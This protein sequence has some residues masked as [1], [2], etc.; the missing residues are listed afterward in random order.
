MAPFYSPK[1]AL[2]KAFPK[3]RDLSKQVNQTMENAE[4]EL[5]KR[6][7]RGCDTSFP[8]A[9]HAEAEWR[10]NCT[11]DY[12]GA[13]YAVE[14][15]KNSLE[16]SDP[17]DALEQDDEGSFAPGTGVW[18]I[19]LDRSTDQLLAR[20]WPWPRPSTFLERINGPIRMVTYLQDLCWSDV[21]R[22]G[23][24]NR[25]ELNLAVSVIVRLIYNG[26][27]AGYLSGPGF[28]PVLE[29]FI[30]DW[31]D[32][33]S[34]F[35]GM[36]YMV[37]NGRTI[38]MPDL[39]LTFHMVRYA[40]HLVRWWPSLIDTL[41]AIRESTYPQGWLDKSGMTDHNNY[42]V[43]ELFQRGW[44]KMLP[45]QRCQAAFHIKEMLNWCLENS[46]DDDGILA[47]P[48]KGDPIPESYYFAAAF[49]D[50][51]GF[52]DS[53]KKFWT[54]DNLQS[55]DSR[56]RGMIAKLKRFNQDFT[57]IDNTLERLGVNHRPWSNAIL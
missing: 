53:S 2:F 56:K 22:C 13:V 50:T 41:L 20:Q 32:P 54:N 5:S 52:F 38:T 15:L 1:A 30:R 28:V 3:M 7:L 18:F 12:E 47:N 34:G 14:Q 48:D 40:P 21:E 27:Q 17:L 42:D 57:V 24:D 31:Q 29:R 33:D 8:R 51:I 9:R 49:L 46:V 35:F 25:K 39:S 55:P 6:E 44:N 43:V 45:S 10:I 23:R 16:I 36:T 19:K 4:K 26:G 37:E 11:N